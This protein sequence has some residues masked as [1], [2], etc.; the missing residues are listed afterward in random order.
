[1][2]PS[3]SLLR[4]L[5]NLCV[6]CVRSVRVP[7]RLRHNPPMSLP[8]IRSVLPGDEPAWQRLWRGYC[9]FYQVRLPAEVTQRTWKRILDPDSGVMCILAEVEGRVAGFA[10]CVVHENTWESQP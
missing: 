8:V 6:L 7:P 9:E 5:R 3:E 2:R 10:H 4:P 1:M